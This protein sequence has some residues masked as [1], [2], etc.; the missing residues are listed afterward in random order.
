MS[1][2]IENVTKT[3]P[4]QRQGLFG[5]GD[6]FTALDDVSLRVAKGASFGLVGESGSGKTT[7]TRCILRLE[8]LTSGR[9]LFDGADVHAL[10]SA[11][12]RRLR[13]RLQIVFQ[14]PYASLD[15]R[16]TIHD[17]VAEPL[18]IHRDVVKMTERQR[19]ERV[20][21]LL[22]Q[23]GLGTQHLFRYP[24]E[25]SGGQRQRIGIARALAV[26]PEF[27]ILDEPTSALDVSVQAEVLN[28]LHRLQVELGL[29]Y[30]FISHDLGVIRYIC[31]D[32]AVIYRGKLVEQ[33]PVA[34]IFDRP[35]NDYTR[36]LLNAMP[37][38]DPDR[39]PFRRPAEAGVG[40]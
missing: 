25:F 12:M 39:S 23:V 27:L 1:L 29:T 19:T 3:F 31:D 2:V 9:I 37:D 22:L 24:H 26:R 4:G 7:L 10:A 30:F 28:L 13:S 15:P 32:V 33:G 38:P 40:A 35:Q 6:S 34:E 21:E 17:I 18:V 11:E 5:R 36:M 16:M 20:A 14:D 8:S